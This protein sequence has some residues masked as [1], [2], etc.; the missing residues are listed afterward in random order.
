MENEREQTL[1]TVSRETDCGLKKKNQ[2]QDL[3]VRVAE[4]KGGLNKEDITHS[5][6]PTLNSGA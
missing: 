3:I 2:T 4:F 1:L 6:S 5:M